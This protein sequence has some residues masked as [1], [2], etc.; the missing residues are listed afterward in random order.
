MAVVIVLLLAAYTGAVLEGAIPESRKIDSA[1]LALL[2]L[3]VFSVLVICYPRMFSRVQSFEVAGVKASFEGLLAAQA[4][5]QTELD[6]IRFVLPLLLPDME[7]KH[8]LN[9]SSLATR[10]YKGNTSVRAELRRLRSM[11]LIR[12]QPDKNVHD[13]KDNV[14]VDLGL[15]VALT[16]LGR[17]WVERIE[18][19]ERTQA[20]E[21]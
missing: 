11:G 1:H 10:G 12:M 16:P 21:P 19:L 5:Q 9:L 3:G 15:F 8:L 2:A 17:L 6:L 18:E 20:R 7:R 14:E 13:I 4:R